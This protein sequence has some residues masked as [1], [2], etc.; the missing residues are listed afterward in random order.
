MQVN[1]LPHQY[2]M[3]SDT[4]S[5]LISCVAG[6][7]AGKT[8]AACYKALHLAQ[9]SPVHVP[10][11]ICEPTYPM[12]R[13]VL[14]PSMDRILE[15]LEIE[16]TFH[17]SHYNY[18]VRIGGGVK[19]I[20]VR[21]GQDPQKLAGSNVGWAILD[22]AG[23]QKEE[24]FK[25]ANSRVRHPDSKC[26]QVVLVGTPEGFNYF[27]QISEA[28]KLET[29]NTIR[30]KTTDNRFLPS[31]YLERL[32]HF[33]EEE[34]KKYIEGQFIAAGGRVYSH[35]DRSK[36]LKPCDDNKAGQTY[37]FADFNIGNMHF[38][39]ARYLSGQI[40]IWGELI[41]VNR[42]TIDQSIEA[43]NYLAAHGIS[44][45]DVTV[46]C[47]AAGSSRQT[48]ATMSDVLILRQAGFDVKHPARNPAIRDRVYSVNQ[49]LAKNL[50]FF[51]PN[52]APF[53]ILSFEQQGFDAYGMPDKRSGHD[54]ATDSCGYG[55][56]FLKPIK[57]P[58]ANHV[59]Y[60]H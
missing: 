7:G 58:R 21:N 49:A 45:G 1:L 23:Q 20:R 15:E 50:L 32:G 47:D 44:P 18:H 42:N 8:T 30:A 36:H 24:T 19:E 13:D 31:D 17:A 5:P 51:D 29:T 43:V 12:C 11:M 37:M 2:E 14:K 27:Y 22:E 52:G 3:I 55:V 54:H 57:M 10:G 25:I 6:L 28:Q 39:F 48:S 41:G 35:F 34:R 59:Q 33:S 56:H 26:R 53:T 60:Y 46:I 38:S 9:M 4:D 16:Y 40:H